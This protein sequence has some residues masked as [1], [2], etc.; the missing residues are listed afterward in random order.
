M[1]AELDHERWGT[2]SPRRGRDGARPEPG[3]I[4]A[5]PEAGASTTTTSWRYGYYDETCYCD[6][7]VRTRSGLRLRLRALL[8]VARNVSR[9]ERS[10]IR[11]EGHSREGHRHPPPLQSGK[12]CL[13][14]NAID[15]FEFVPR[16]L[17]SAVL[18]SSLKTS[19]LRRTHPG[20]GCKPMYRSAAPSG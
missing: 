15:R 2:A 6:V 1:P 17:V 13:T 14:Q 20:Y 3:R 7:R 5:G 4:I 10:E 8:L 9:I 16:R 12:G 18:E 11:S 19:S